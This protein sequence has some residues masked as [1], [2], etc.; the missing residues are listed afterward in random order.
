MEVTF[1]KTNLPYAAYIVSVLTNNG[2][3]FTVSNDNDSKLTTSTGET[4]TGNFEIAHYFAT[5]GNDNLPLTSSEDA[6][7]FT[8]A[9]NEL[10]STQSEKFEV[11]YQKL[12]AHLQMRTFFAGYDITLSDL[13]VYEAL[14]VNFNQWNGFKAVFGPQVPH[15][16]RWFTYLDTHPTIQNASKMLLQ[17]VKKGASTKETTSKSDTKKNTQLETTEGSFEVD[18][19]DVEIGKVVVRFPPEASGYLHIGHAKAALINDYFAQR[20]KGTL[21]MRFDDTN[22]SKEKME[23]EHS[24]LEDLKK[25]EVKPHKFTYTSDYFDLC[26][27]FAEKMI[28][29]GTAYVDKTSKEQLRIEKRNGIESK[30]RNNSVEENLRLWKEMIAASEEGL[31]CCLRAKINMQAANMTLRDPV[32]YRCNLLPHNRT[33]TK[34]KV[35]PT[36]DFAC[37]IV[38]SIEG[39]THTLRTTEYHDRN[40]QFF[41]IIDALGIRKPH[42]WDYS[43]LNMAY[44]VMSKRKLLWF[45]ETGRVS[46]WDDP[47]FPT[48]RGLLRRGLTVKALRQFVLAQGASKS[49]T[50]QSW[51]KL[52]T[53]NKKIIDPIVPRF[54]AVGKDSVRFHLANGPASVEL[55][56]VPKHK[57]NPELGIKA[58]KL[59]NTI[60]LEREDADLI[61]E[62]EEVTLMDWGNAI[63]QK[64]NK[65]ADGKITSLE[66][67]LHLEGSVKD[68]EK[69]LTWL[70]AS[71]DLL[72]VTLVDYGYLI[73][74]AKLEPEDKFEDYINPNS[75]FEV[76]VLGDRNLASLKKGDSIQL[77]RRGYYIVDEEYNENTKKLTLLNIPDGREKKPPAAT[78]TN[79]KQ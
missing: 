77:E 43:R 46:G 52:W 76:D 74:K 11:A 65:D 36:Y 29:E 6:K 5:Q 28:K 67:V 31:Q 16:V 56:E 7:W 70:A 57:K 53:I 51:E 18:L 15:L 78:T 33:G 75:K 50:N 14:K 42:I 63:V 13:A 58:I 38:D 24:I 64:L 12:N 61:K 10:K 44:T 68:T 27:E 1:P 59:S 34:Y 69:K 79:N 20:Y 49:I 9:N 25:L 21:I 37:P 71:D 41:W 48:V 35:Y 26:M 30:Y 66:G 45:V 39:V 19:P 2:A 54:T 17:A 40:A 22:P 4:I 72:P 55:K 62:N 47:R 32:L 73:T 8:F 23:Y 60:L 3:N